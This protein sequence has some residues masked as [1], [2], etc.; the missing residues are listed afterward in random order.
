MRTHTITTRIGRR[1]RP[2][3][4]MAV[5]FAALFV[6]LGG[7]A[8][9]QGTPPP[10]T[11]PATCNGLAATVVGTEGSDDLRMNGT[12]GPDVIVG[13][14]GD[15]ILGRTA[16]DDVICGGDGRDELFG[17]RGNDTL[18]GEAGKDSLGD[19]SGNDTL[20]GG[21]GGDSLAAG[22]GNDTLLGGPGK[23][24]LFGEAGKDLCVGGP[25]KDIDRVV[26][27][28]SFIAPVPHKCEVK[29]SI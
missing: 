17:G 8:L 4:A 24:W 23:D 13:L 18:L 5:A 25:G 29:K 16:G 28:G 3:P 26:H 12:P 2:S 10:G 14:G 19:R 9:S 1:L 15:D 21:P 20:L 6:A 7:T 27:N 22:P 11:A